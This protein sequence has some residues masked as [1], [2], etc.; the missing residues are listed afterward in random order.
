MPKRPSIE[1]EGTLSDRS[2]HPIQFLEF[3]SL[4]HFRVIFRATVG[5]LVM[6]LQ[7]CQTSDVQI[8]K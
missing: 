5:T 6:L 3:G 8:K 4:L 1:G 2:L 7:L